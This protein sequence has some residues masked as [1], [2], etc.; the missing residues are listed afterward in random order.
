MMKWCQ[1]VAICSFM[2][3][4]LHLYILSTM[5]VKPK[6]LCNCVLSIVL[7]PLEWRCKLQRGSDRVNAN[8]SPH[9]K[10]YFMHKTP[11]GIR[12]LTGAFVSKI[13]VFSRFSWSLD[14]SAKIA[15]FPLPDLQIR[16]SR[17]RVALFKSV[18]MASRPQ[19]SARPPC[20]DRRRCD[21]D[22]TMQVH[23]SSQPIRCCKA[24][25]PRAG[26]AVDRFWTGC[27]VDAMAVVWQNHIG[28]NIK[29]TFKLRPSIHN[30]IANLFMEA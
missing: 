24:W 4:T 19:R 13:G 2:C 20:F 28:K 21:H 16:R 22:V 17:K 6:C 11:C 27:H 1:L 8:F 7:I 26:N 12:K 3:E 5:L 29:I 10:N 14:V 9:P 18:S 23:E 25:R 30:R 15:E